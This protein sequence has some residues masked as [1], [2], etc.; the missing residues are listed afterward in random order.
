M[1]N[2]SD[3][4]KLAETSLA[5]YAFDLA[6]GKGN[7]A[8][9]QRADMSPSQAQRFDAT[10]QVLGQQDLSDGFSA[11]LFQQVDALGQPV[12]QKVLAIRGSEGS[13]WG[14]DYLVDAIGVAFLGTSAGL[15]QYNSLQ[16]FY[17][18]LVAQGK[19]GA[20]EGIVVAGHSLGGFLAQAFTAKHDVVSAAYTYNAPGF[21]IA[22]GVVTNLGTE[23]LKL[24]GLS[25][26]VPNE[27][28]FNVRALDGISGTAGLG[29]MIGSVQ[30]VNIEAGNPIHNHSIVTLTDALSVDDLFARM[31]GNL[32]IGDIAAIFNAA[33]NQANKSL[34]SAL[35]DLRQLF[36]GK[37]TVNA[38]PTKLDD[39]ESFYTNLYGL[40]SSSAFQ[41]W[42]GQVSVVS[43]ADKPADAIRSLAQNDMSYRYALR[44][45]TPFAITGAPG[46]YDAFNTN[47]ELGLYDPTTESG[48][49][50]TRYLTDRAQMLFWQMARNTNDVANLVR[51]TDGGPSVD[52]VNYR[53]VV[54]NGKEVTVKDTVLVRGG[55]GVGKLGPQA[56]RAFGSDKANTLT[57][58]GF[59]DELFGGGGKD[60]LD[61]RGGD[62]YLEG[63]QGDD[64]LIGGEGNDTYVYLGQEG[65][66]KIVDSDGLGKIVFAG[67]DLSGT[68][69]QKGAN[70]K[71]FG[72]AEF[73][74]T[75][76]GKLNA[77]GSPEGTGMLNITKDGD[78]SGMVTIQGFNNAT[79]FVG[80]NLNGVPSTQPL[81][82]KSGTNANDTLSADAPFQKVFGLDGNDRII[83]ATAGAEA[84][85]GTGND[86][87]SNDTG[88]QKLYGDE[89]NDILVASGGND[90]LY[91]GLGNDALQG[92][93]DDD[94]LE[95]NDG[96]D[97]L[98]GGAG[99]D[100][101]IGGE[102][103]DFLL[104]G[105]SLVPYFLPAW[106]PANIP[107]FGVL[108]VNGVAGVTNM[109][110]YLNI[111]GDAAD[112]LDGGAGNDTL[113]AGDGDDLLTGGTGDDL[114]DGQA[115]SDTLYGGDGADILYGDGTQGSLSVGGQDPYTLPQ[116]HGD[117]YLDGGAGDDFLTGDGG[118]DELYGGDGNDTLV[119]DASGLD[120][121]YHGSDYIDG[122]AGDDQL[123]GYGKD[124]TLIGGAG[125]DVVEGDSSTV[126]YAK[127]GNDYLDGG[128]GDDI[129]N[130]D[131][132][133]DT[134]YGGAGND[135]LFG[136]SDDTPVQY[137][138]DDYLDG[139]AGDDYLRGYGGNDT[140][141]GGDGADQLLGEAGDDYLDGEAGDDLMSGGDGNDQLFGGAGVD[142]LQGDAGDDYL[143]GED[144]N[145]FV[146]GGSG[147]D[148]L[149]GGAG[150]DQLAGDDGDDVLDGGAGDDTLFGDAG[151]DTL[152]G[153]DGNDLIT[154]GSGNDQVSGGAGDDQLAGESG[155]DVLDGG[156]GDDTLYGDAGKDTL[157]GGAGGDRI[158]SGEGDDNASGGDG[159]DIIF[160]EA[161][162]D[163]LAGDEGND[164]L[165][166]GEGDDRLDGGEG[167]DTLFGDE[168]NDVLI[169]G[170]GDNY[171][172]GGPGNDILIGGARS[173][174]YYWQ[175]GDGVDRIYDTTSKS[176]GVGV[177]ALLFGPG[178][179]AYQGSLR[180]GSLMLDLGNGEGIH[181][182]NFDPDNVAA[183]AGID[184]FV[185]ADGVTLGYKQLIARGFD[186][187]GT[188]DADVIEGTST[189][190]RINALAGDD[191]VM[192]KRGEDIIDLGA[193]DDFADAGDGNDVVF[194]GDGADLVFGVA[195]DD[196]L[197]GG[198]GNDTL[199]GGAG[200]DSLDGGAG[201]DQLAGGEGNDTLTGG[202]GADTLAGGTGNDVYIVDAQDSVIENA[203]EG[204]DTV[205]AD[206][207]YT[208]LD[209]VENLTL[210]G[211]D[212]LSGSGN[213]L[214]NVISGNGGDNVLLGLAGNDRIY[215]N[216]GNDTLDGGAGADVMLGGAG[217]DTYVVDDPGDVIGEQ[218]DVHYR[219][220]D[221]STGIMT[222]YVIT[223]GIDTV[224]SSS[225][226]TLGYDL[227]NLTLTGSAAIDGRGNIE[228]NVILGNDA[229]NVLTAYTLNRK[230]DNRISIG[231]MFSDPRSGAEE[232]LMDRAAQALYKEDEHYIVGTRELGPRAG[233][234]L[235]GGAGNDTLLGD[236]D[237]DT[238]IGGEGND[239][240]FGFG[241]AD[242]LVGGTGDDSYVVDVGYHYVLGYANGFSLEYQDE[243]W[244][245]LIE[246]PGEGTDTVLS[247]I[248]YDLD[249]NIE[250]LTLLDS[251]EA[252][253][254]DIGVY[255]SASYNADFHIAHVGIGNELDNVIT[256]NH[257]GDLLYGLDGNDTIIGGAGND[258]LDG[259]SGADTMRGGSGDDLYRVDDSG[260]VVF[261]AGATGAEQGID[262]VESQISYTLGA[263]VENLAL[264]GDGVALNG[265]GNELDNVIIGDDS[266]NVL[267]GKGGSDSLY[268]NGGEDTL[269]GG[270]GNDVLDGGAGDDFMTGG[271]G[272]DT[273]YVDSTADI[274]TEAADEGYDSV[275]AGV[276]HTLGA[277][278]EVLY[279][280]GAGDID[281]TG[282]DSDNLIVGNDGSN[283]LSG[284]GGNDVI[285]G[286]AG[287]DTIAGGDGDDVI[288]AGEGFDYLS[289]GAGND[290]L[291]GGRDG[292][293]MEGGAGDDTYYVDDWGDSVYEAPGEGHDTVDSTIDYAL[294]DAVEDLTLLGDFQG[295]MYGSGLWGQGNE[296]DNRIIGS[297]TSNDLSGLGGDDVIDGRADSDA[298]YGG[299]GNDT[300]Y[301][302]D[303]ATFAVDI[304]SAGSSDGEQVGTGPMHVQ[305]LAMNDDHLY[306]EA[307]NDAIDGGS[308][309]DQIYGGEGDDHLY[310]GDDGIA[311]TG[312]R[313]YAARS[314]SG[315]MFAAV[316][317]GDPANDSGT[318][319]YGDTR[320]QQINSSGPL[321]LGNDDYIDGGFGNDFIDG[322]SGN[323]ELYG[324]D[325]NDSLY[326]GADGPLNTSNNDYLDGGAGID[327]MA[328]GTGD[329][330]YVV[331]GS[332]TETSDIPVYGDCGDLIPGAV[333]RVWTTDTAVEN[334]NEGYDTVYSSADYTLPDNVEDL[335]LQWY[336]DARIGRGNAGDNGI[337]GNDND[338]RLEGGA[339]NDV[340]DGGW[341]NDVLDGGAGDDA[342][343]GGAGDDTYNLGI[344]AGHDTVFNDGGGFDR[345]HILNHLTADDITVSRGGNGNDV[346]IGLNGTQDRM[347]LSNWFASADP[348]SEIDFC[349]DSSLDANAIADLVNA[350]VVTANDDFASVQEDAVP[351]ATGNVLDNDTDSLNHA[352]SVTNPGTVAGAY[353]TLALAVDGSYT[354]AL[355]NDAVQWL[356]EGES[357]TD[358]F[359]YAVEDTFQAY[360]Q[361]V[362]YVGIDGQNDAPLISPASGE[363]VE[364]A[365]PVTVITQ[366]DNL[367]VNS[368][369][370]NVDF[371]GW[372]VTNSA[373]SIGFVSPAHSGPYGAFFGWGLTDG[374]MSQDVPTVEGQDYTVDFWLSNFG[375]S[376]ANTEFDARWNDVTLASLAN[377]YLPGYTDY[378]FDVA[379]A[380]GS[381]HLEFSVRSDWMLGLDD[382]TVTPYTTQEVAP[383]TQS[384]TGTVAF[385]DVDLGDSHGISVQPQGA[386][387]LG[388]FDATLAQD[389]TGSGSASVAWNFSVDNGAIQYLAEGQT[390]TQNY[391]VTID[392]GHAGGSVTQAVA[393]N[394]VGTNDAPVITDWDSFGAILEDAPVDNG[395]G[396]MVMPAV[397]KVDGAM[398]FS[399]VDLIDTHSVTV[400]AADT[401][402]VGSLQAVVTG[403]STGT[404]F[405]SVDWE[406]AVDNSAIDFL[407]E[408]ETLEQSYNVVIDDSHTD[409]TAAQSVTVLITGAND[410][411]S[412]GAAASAVTEDA[413]PAMGM[414]AGDNLLA[415]GGF[416]SGDL[417]GWNLAGNTDQVGVDNVSFDGSFAGLFGAIGS[418]GIL[419]QDVETTAGQQYLLDFRL[420]G[421]GD[422]GADFSV[423]WNGDALAAL[424]DVS[425]P[426]YSEFQ[427]V[428]S[429]ADGLSHLEFALRNDPDFWR[430]D[431]I[432]LRPLLPGAIVPSQEST[433]GAIAFADA[434]LSD[435]HDMDV[436]AEGPN[437]LGEFIL[438]ELH[439]STGTG[440]GSIDWSFT[441]EDSAIQY[442]AEGESLTQYYDATVYDDYTSGTGT[443]AVTVTINGANDAPVITSADS[444]A[445]VFE[446]DPVLSAGGAI[447]FADADLIDTHS[448]SVVAANAGYVG[449]FQAQ[450]VADSMGM[451]SG[452]VEWT[453]AADKSAIAFLA[454]GETLTQHFEVGIDDGHAGGTANQGVDVVITGT[455]D[456]AVAQDDAASVQED[457]TLFVAGN[458]LANDGDADHGTALSVVAPGTFFG[459]YGTL[460][461]AADGTYSYTL[462]NASLAVQSLADGEVVHDD[463]T[464]AA[465]DGFATTGAL[466]EADI[467]GTNDAP[468]V[469]NDAAMVQED[470][471]LV[472]SG[473][474]LANDSDIDVG[475]VLTVTAPD[476]Y[477][478]A[479]GTL[480]LAADGSYTYTL[481]KAPA[482]TQHDIFAYA[483]TDGIVGTPG[484]LTVNIGGGNDAPV[485]VNDP[486]SAQEDAVLS[487]SGNVLAN[488]S[489]PDVGTVLQV[490][491]PGI[492]SG[493]YGSLNLA[494][495][496]AYTY[497]LANASGAVQALA[498]GQAVTD[499]FGYAATDGIVST[500]GT[501]TVTVTGTNDAPLAQNDTGA[502]Q[503]DGGPVTLSG[504]L[505]LANDTDVDAGDTRIITAAANSAAGALVNLAGGNVVYD[506]GTL[507][508]TLKQGATTTDTFTY[509]MADGAG[510]TSSA[511]V[512]M[513]L[514]GVND[515]PVVAN[516][517][518]DQ[519]AA[520]GSAFNFSFAANSFTDIDVDDSLAYTA[521][522]SDGTALPSWLSFNAASRTFT[523]TP[524]GGTGT[525]GNCGT[526][527]ASSL[528]LR[529]NATDTAG[530]S[531]FG[532][533]AL[534]ISGS[535]G[536]S[537]GGQTIIGTDQDDVLAGTPCNDIIDGRLG[538]DR[539]SGGKGDDVYY[540]DETC[541]SSSDQHGNEGVGNGEDP[542]PPGHDHNQNDGPGTSPGDPG[543]RDGGNDHY[544]GQSG[545]DS[546]TQCRVD[547]V[548]ENPNEGYDTVYSTA[549]Y[550]LTANVEELHLIGCDDLTGHGNALA[551]IIVGNTG[552]NALYGEA[553]DDL[554]MDDAG[555]DALYGG[556]GND[557]LDGGAGEDTFIGG[558]GDDTYIHSLTGGDDVVEE[559]GG[560][561]TIRFGEGI[562]ASAVSVLREQNDLVLKL[563]GQNGSVTVK[564]WFSGSASRVERVQFADG[565]V[566]NETQMRALAGHGSS[567]GSGG[568]SSDGG[569][570][571]SG[572]D[573]G[574]SSRQDNG[575]S[576]H[577]G[578]QCDNTRP[579]GSSQCCDERDA[580][581]ARL[582]VSPNYDFTSLSTYL[583]QHPG[584]GYGALTAAQ[585]AQQWRCV[586][587]RVGQLAQDD[588]D[589]RHGAHGGGQYGSDDGLAHGA[590]FWGY[591]GSTGQ[592]G[593]QGGMAS[594]SGL[595]EGFTKLG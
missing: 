400:T 342:L 115:G 242:T 571:D 179:V 293:T 105:G 72:N 253:E 303:D 386:D 234:T 252:W 237:D 403:D 6:V 15:S 443:Q 572:H 187:D 277:N 217:D 508:Q 235:V 20:T 43:L 406:F 488:D 65:N 77:A 373:G 519:N 28:I 297:D 561:D 553:G 222:D 120:E 372:N 315:E 197:D 320:F 556:A 182:E 219:D 428:V 190:D 40:Q 89:G 427:Y 515:A 484:T 366:G 268:G 70:A 240:L 304:D 143:A 162:D 13:H 189:S 137:Q 593:S 313:Y 446:D 61:G 358:S 154:A 172:E 287:D 294:P 415:N 53:D 279:L 522:L 5:A 56:Q 71:A 48:Q 526:G 383:A 417:S 398:Y 273:Y 442:L 361:G 18:S 44:E 441:I 4:L 34:E 327:T 31:D 491:A 371:T 150:D 38:T 559:S 124:D 595:G 134:L 465:T 462:D 278:I 130:G 151:N 451:D 457:L 186:L 416:E 140:L 78:A 393:V 478:G 450:V 269:D 267:V 338:N 302:G 471:P 126:P 440:F 568:G 36:L 255:G 247:N 176:A 159:D 201:A 352:L 461:L 362:L 445:E 545:S 438:G 331:D 283:N 215:G 578:G 152:N 37:Q 241:G 469:V 236:L 370:D 539:M 523:G 104:G 511:S 63:G 67:Q 212:D 133:S 517:I 139:E 332:Y 224:E 459:A 591:A 213:E 379:G 225:S 90:E 476:T 181:L 35:H 9:Y 516:P 384:V 220:I 475:T 214:D 57:G 348:V 149:L 295:D 55:T 577:G 490:A 391:D 265:I 84:Y 318:F 554:L 353:G 521:T 587:N 148:Q 292:D 100:V 435:V 211:W 333:T 377:P 467:T 425:L 227:E 560:Q 472:A 296:F 495:D 110:G 262:T 270:D 160:G 463:F 356:A 444:S 173:D 228:Q 562:A 594:F 421:G 248:D 75:W 10:W 380:A 230:P 32:S 82:D 188:P 493:A 324:G 141:F 357:V 216:E 289:G 501:L 376:T 81:T 555:N 59:A 414:V 412:V 272:D 291:D 581:A 207:S 585:V 122:G 14:I 66:D 592:G 229:D 286:G 453:F 127:H 310:G 275:H 282:N 424:A 88:E 468:V 85:G 29:Q 533:F 566:W 437:Y 433:S 363:V 200:D 590:M 27:K 579:S 527:T 156:A 347:V 45:L 11:V 203:G 439:D 309:N 170:A 322:G 413:A 259:G 301:G 359:S 525:G 164:E 264:F 103:S 123:F 529:V 520:A 567:G 343:Y 541:P 204:N 22:P 345:V 401:G 206:F 184:Q 565:S 12:G 395:A 563:S 316:S 261:E 382:V 492:Y 582:Q 480:I 142:D 306:G 436:E 299:D 263:N 117:D 448:V 456:A 33:S 512:T 494:A 535:G 145:D 532:V 420:S 329:D 108:I 114:I 246:N 479:Y 474:V 426:D 419:S 307:G 576:G 69:A 171:F 238:L 503:E 558:A 91:G 168:G 390:L 411:P 221:P 284:L 132:G 340:L 83:V 455:N 399:D 504:A 175:P 326:G 98:D 549:D 466:F 8:K 355:A 392:D 367:V 298:I 266:D 256:G 107:D 418:E 330:T 449:S 537:G 280:E 447:A 552:D 586:Q 344:G 458:V 2:I 460:S 131:G 502:A 396:G 257:A 319:Y 368:S 402:Y 397:E 128:D 39:R 95:G 125:N 87:I 239:V 251:T 288:A 109:V 23:L 147:N 574:H 195:G 118:S 487:A 178:V 49:L 588:E 260:D 250:N 311:V 97:V 285:A 245:N 119:G 505:L 308:G 429:G 374:L 365:N 388:S 300:L 430:M 218:A 550:T 536:G 158:Q 73:T 112:V 121:Q 290:T 174:V 408:G 328:G 404:G 94:Y 548:I 510:A 191:V 199:D 271:A 155:D 410:A 321:F 21:S 351:V 180:L 192:A 497:T 538:F 482:Q 423:N 76:D 464:Y 499:V 243:S 153:G 193:G 405:G 335:Y 434:D 325:G 80:I 99:S 86:Y 341:G 573:D 3:Y 369:F 540:V 26:T 101:I 165:H 317:G 24:F 375:F 496:G 514:T 409:G 323:D 116:F 387:Y 167:D 258:T 528:Q 50:T 349:D 454:A 163:I 518:P 146:S 513:T 244:D 544:D 542:P 96:N 575:S 389:S 102:G 93:A 111:E 138:G 198:A 68:Y 385:S 569:S 1:P 7:T 208:L 135:Q 498:A 157:T 58:Y 196:M 354:Y 432:T 473:N 136:D 79:T 16:N 431:D 194:A 233:D 113:L 54:L 407:A 312:E 530:A 46:L 92:G 41:A 51:R 305:I 254:Q 489:D 226:Y 17:L 62:D 547:E 144:G 551:N 557:V 506:T 452:L 74:L 483:A 30:T 364:D 507:F 589:A 509:T 486:A 276:S 249:A 346:I 583:A 543:S 209:N 337:Y 350:H 281:G 336:S 47:G 169:G 166:G 546:G 394:L 177:N 485:V 185:F 314:E 334:A 232:R 378:Q 161:G 210:D 500:P 534:N 481:D 25:G 231:D 531:A 477:A 360:A 339:G 60:T 202:E 129:L 381:S 564:N 584:G 274:T 64:A 223:G 524:L 52:F 570:S 470:G 183:G 580:I 42:A 422:D 205:R 19:L 106:D